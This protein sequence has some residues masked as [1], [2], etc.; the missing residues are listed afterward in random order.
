MCTL[1]WRAR[2]SQHTP[3]CG[4]KWWIWVVGLG[5]GG[6]HD[7]VG[8]HKLERGSMHAWVIL[9]LCLSVM[10]S[11]LIRHYPEFIIAS[12]VSAASSAY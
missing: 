3:R 12:M 7:V 11:C 5:G 8:V 4:S 1:R 2:A 9:V 10:V 6:V